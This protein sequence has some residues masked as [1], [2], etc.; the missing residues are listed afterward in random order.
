M[1]L[2][3]FSETNPTPKRKIH[4]VIDGVDGCAFRQ[5]FPHLLW[6]ESEITNNT[7]MLLAKGVN[8]YERICENCYRAFR[9]N[10][11]G[12]APSFST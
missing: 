6:D 10:L 12:K 9:K 7:F 1:I 8:P 4:L 2:A 11:L 3:I 5:R